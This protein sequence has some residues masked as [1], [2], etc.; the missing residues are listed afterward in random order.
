MTQAK[1]SRM[2]HVAV[3]VSDTN[4]SIEWYRRVLGFKVTERHPA[5]E[6]D[7]IPVEFDPSCGLQT[8]HHEIVLVHNPVKTYRKKP[9]PE[10]DIDGPPNLHHAALECDDREAWL[11]LLDHIR[12]S[13]AEIVRGPVLHSFVQT[14]GRR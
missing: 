5:F 3:E 4:R 9:L 8:I 11:R 14:R 10:N 2:Q 12:I 1:P 6:V 13:G 7:G